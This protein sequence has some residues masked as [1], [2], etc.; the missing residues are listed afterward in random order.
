MQ[1]LIKLSMILFICFLQLLSCNKKKYGDVIFWQKTGSGF[2]ITNVSINEHIAAITE[3][4]NFDPGCEASGV[5]VFTNLEEG[6]YNYTAFDGAQ[7]W[8]GMVSISEGC[9]SIELN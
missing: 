2:G 6:V 3:E 5:A 9:V 4:Y 1:Q 7:S 8:S